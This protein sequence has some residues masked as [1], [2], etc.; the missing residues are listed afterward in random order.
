MLEQLGVYTDEDFPGGKSL[1]S[2][3]VSALADLSGALQVPSRHFALLLAGDAQGWSDE[4]ILASARKLIAK[5]LA[6]LVAW[7]PDCERVHDLFDQARDPEESDASVI[8]TTWHGDETLD[9]TLWYFVGCAS[10]ADDFAETCTSWVAASVNHP[11]WAEHMH[12]RMEGSKALLSASADEDAFDRESTDIAHD[13]EEMSP[14]ALG[15]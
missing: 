11:G 4:D 5:G 2:V 6:V 8:L 1:F 15:G 7:G 10:A 14:P 9:E 12:I 13:Q 3:G